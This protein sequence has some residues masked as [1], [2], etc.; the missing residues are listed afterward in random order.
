M[1]IAPPIALAA[2]PTNKAALRYSLLNAAVGPLDMPDGARLVDLRYTVPW[3]GPGGTA[4]IP[5]CGAFGVPEGPLDIA[6]G[7]ATVLER[8]F[9]CQA[10]GFENGAQVEELMLD[11]LEVSEP[12][13]LEAAL[14]AYL[15]TTTAFDLGSAATMAAAVS[16][17]ETYAYTTQGYG[18]TATMHLPIGAFAYLASEYLITRESATGVWR[19]N[20]G[21]IVAPNAS[22]TDHAFITGL[23]VVW[24]APQPFI[25]EAAEALDRGD[26]LYKMVG[27][28]DYIV[29]WECFTATIE[30][31][32]L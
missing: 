25:P 12:R 31:G 16:A 22:L 29:A 7:F 14:A 32:V 5:E 26:N 24:R 21:T 6:D 23:T 19:T 20:L 3:C 27:Q 11:R 8:R 9:E 13:L 2:P 10:S 1:A 15:A 17:M 4:Y 30:L 18:L 28:R